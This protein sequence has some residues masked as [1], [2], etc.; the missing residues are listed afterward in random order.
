MDRGPYGRKDRLIKEKRHDVFQHRA[1]WPEPT[2]CPRCGA[3]FV[4]GRWTWKQVPEGTHH[5]TCPAC[6]RI[7]EHL[8]CGHIEIS[9]AFAAEHRTDLLNL[10]R[11]VETREKNAHPLERI[12]ELEE[13]GGRVTVTTTGVHLA[14]GIGDALTRAFKGDLSVDYSEEENRVR[15]KWER[16]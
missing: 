7:A 11:N 8:P 2:L 4:G 6:R 9:G 10:I 3:A 13:N 16:N 14:R 5:A 1:K 15:I 12:M